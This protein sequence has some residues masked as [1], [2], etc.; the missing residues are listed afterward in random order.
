MGFISL[1]VFFSCSRVIGDLSRSGLAVREERMKDYADGLRRLCS[2][3]SLE[4]LFC[5]CGSATD[6][7]RVCF[8]KVQRGIKNLRLKNLLGL[9]SSLHVLL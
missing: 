3:R 1:E 4:R 7:E 8:D 6:S 9:G 2:E 5:A